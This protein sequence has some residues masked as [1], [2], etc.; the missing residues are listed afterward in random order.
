MFKTWSLFVVA[1]VSL[2]SF[3][4]QECRAAKT[5]NIVFIFTDDHAPQAIGAYNGW[6]KGV[7]PTPNIDKLAAQGMLFQNSFCTNSICGPS[8]AVI[9]TGKHSHVN[10]FMTNSDRFRSADVSKVASE[11]GLL[12]SDDREVAS[13]DRSA[14]F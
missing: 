3:C 5:P 12:D 7:N 9:L 1:V 11:S 13:D 8:R 10:G 4:L 14:R 6:L 2:G